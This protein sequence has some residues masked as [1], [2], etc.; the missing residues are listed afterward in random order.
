[1]DT[2]N[3]KVWPEPGGSLASRL[4]SHYRMALMVKYM[5]GDSTAPGVTTIDMLVKSLREFAKAAGEVEGYP[6]R[7]SLQQTREH[8]Q[9]LW[10]KIH[11]AKKP[12]WKI[13]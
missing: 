2:Y 7:P 10:D 3:G 6:L 4:W 12:W 13:W 8:G 5:E 11:V 9:K 1:M